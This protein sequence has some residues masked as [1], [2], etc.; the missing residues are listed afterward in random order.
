MRPPKRARG[1]SRATS[2]LSAEVQTP[3]GPTTAT[4][5]PEK[6]EGPATPGLPLL[7]PWTDEEEISLFKGLVRW[8]PAGIPSCSPRKS[9]PDS[10]EKILRALSRFMLERGHDPKNAPHTSIPGIWRKL[11]SLYNLEAIDEREN[12]VFD[13]D[14][15]DDDD[16]DDSEDPSKEPFRP[17]ALPE[18][19]Y[20]EM[21]FSRRLASEASSSP[22]ILDKPVPAS[23]AKRG[24]GRGGRSSGKA[25]RASTVEDTAEEDPKSSTPVPTGP[26]K[27]A[28]NT[29]SSNARSKS[30]TSPEPKPSVAKKRRQTRAQVEEQETEDVTGAE[31]DGEDDE[32]GHRDDSTMAGSPA[33]TSSVVPPI[34][35]KTSGKQQETQGGRDLRRSSRKK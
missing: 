13:D 21:M 19:E 31:A 34:S 6:S 11:R 2:T 32:D 9:N 14:E 7:D 5:S 26:R 30:R 1:G 10:K 24:G 4:Q 33:T 17:F 27:S 22:S 3:V 20:G 16:D 25:T 8:K 35:K 23:A 15:D 28:R 18:D 29:R 12:S